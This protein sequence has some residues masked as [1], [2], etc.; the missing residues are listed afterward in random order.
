MDD[1]LQCGKVINK[2]VKHMEYM[3]NYNER[4][5]KFGYNF[6]VNTNNYALSPAV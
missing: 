2:V 4:G 6:K 1:L 3:D 5:S